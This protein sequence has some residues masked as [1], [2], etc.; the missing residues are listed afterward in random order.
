VHFAEDD[1]AN[2]ERY[3]TMEVEHRFFNFKAHGHLI[4]QFPTVICWDIN[5]KPRLAPKPTAKPYKFVVQLEEAMLRIYTISR[6]PGVSVATE[7]E[8]QRKRETAEWAS[9]L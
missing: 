3:A 7:E 9:N 6:M 1:A 2:A 5:P 4:P 8:L